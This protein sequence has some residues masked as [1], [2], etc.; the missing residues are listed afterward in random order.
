MSTENNNN[1]APTIIPVVNDPTELSAIDPELL[2]L[3]FFNSAQRLFSFGGDDIVTELNKLSTE[4]RQPLRELLGNKCRLKFADL[5][6]RKI[7]KRTAT[8]GITSDIMVMGASI[9]NATAHKDLDKIFKPAAILPDNPTIITPVDVP[10][11]IPSLVKIVVSLRDRVTKLET[12]VKSLKEMSL[13]N[14]PESDK[15]EDDEETND[16]EEEEVEEGEGSEE[17]D[18]EEEESDEEESEEEEEEKE[19]AVTTTEQSSAKVSQKKKII[20]LAASVKN[21]KIVP[22]AA[23]V[24]KSEKLS[25]SIFVGNVK[26]KCTAASLEDF[27]KKNCKATHA[28]VS[29]ISK[30]KQKSSYKIEVSQKVYKSVLTC[31]KWPEDVSVKPFQ[32]MDSKPKPK[33]GSNYLEYNGGKHGNHGQSQLSGNQRRR[34]S[35]PGQNYQAARG[36]PTKPGRYYRNQRYHRPDFSGG[37]YSRYYDHPS[38][39]PRYSPWEED[40]EYEYMYS[41]RR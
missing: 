29:L 7:R 12:E 19:E 15:E 40:W 13:E 22:L 28:Q 27:I 30:N 35:H 23:A 2:P 31:S 39:G 36:K 17:E 34:R 3:A 16:E 26:P 20:P 24:G 25:K 41:P 38:N 21:V 6:N 4:V 10:T 14:P 33:Q 1:M 18:S 11:D 37:P 9:A 5:T 32:V 8:I